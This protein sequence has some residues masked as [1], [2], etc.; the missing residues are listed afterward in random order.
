M[1]NILLKYFTV[2]LLL[3]SWNSGYGAMSLSTE[4]ELPLHAS[5][6]AY[7]PCVAFARDNYVVAWQ[8]GRIGPGSIRNGMNY[9][10]DIVGV[11]VSQ[12]G[13]VVSSEPF[14]ICQAP[15]LQ[16]R[17]RA[18]AVKDTVLVVWQDLRNYRNWDIY[19]AR[20]LAN[21]QVLDPGG[22]LISGGAHN[23][24]KPNV[25]WDGKTFIVVWQDFRDGVKY[26]PY[27]ARVTSDGRVLDASGILLPST[28][29][30]NGSTDPAVTSSGDG[31]SL[32][33]WCGGAG[34]VTGRGTMGLGLFLKDGVAGSYIFKMDA[35]DGVSR[36]TPGFGNVPVFLA[37]APNGFLITWR[38][39]H[40][41]GRT[42]GDN[43]ANAYVIDSLGAMVDT[44]TLSGA[45]H[46]ILGADVVWDGSA[47]VAAWTELRDQTAQT[48]VDYPSATASERVLVSRIALRGAIAD[49]KQEVAGSFTAPAMNPGVASNM[50]GKTLI[51]YEKQPVT[52]DIPIKIGCRLLSVQ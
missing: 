32:V 26:F 7:V 43:T 52:A 5:R 37:A 29:N 20:V 38:N 8:S 13:G 50:A 40:P 16:E 30:Q 17:P 10:G 27:A 19:G 36:A 6:D 45:S 46:R 24:A 18:A 31:R 1:R 41:I 9:I 51:V 15:D 14:V 11:C 42:N 49:A 3:F 35:G 44:L 28:M 47:F 25:T 23:Q 22:F 33:F 39:E 4:A 12:S 21:G 2:F 48:T 34:T